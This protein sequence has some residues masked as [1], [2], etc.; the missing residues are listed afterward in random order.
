M[1]SF[2][3]TDIFVIGGGPAG[4]TIANR[5]AGMG[6][7]VLLAEAT[8]FPRHRVDASLP[9]IIWPLL[10]AIGVTE[11]IA[12]A[13]FIP[14]RAPIVVWPH[15]RASTLS[16]ERE[17][18]G[19]YVERARFDAILLEAAALAGV[20]TIEGARA[21]RPVRDE[22][23]GWR[24]PIKF[25]ANQQTVVSSHIIV[26]ASGGRL[27]PGAPSR[28]GPTTLAVFARWDNLS[29]EPQRAILEA[30]ENE[31]LWCAPVGPRELIAIAFIEPK[32]LS[33][34]DRSAI[35]S[36]YLEILGRS[37][38]IGSVLVDARLNEIRICDATCRAAE[39]H[40]ELGY[41][42]VGDASLK[43]DP[44]SSQGV[45]VAIASALQAAVIANTMLRKPQSSSMAINFYDDRQRERLGAHI[46]K[47]AS[48]YNKVAS[49]FSSQFWKE[50][51]ASHEPEPGE[52]LS[53]VAALRTD[54]IIEL[55]SSARFEEAAVIEGD[56]VVQRLGLRLPEWR[57]PIAYLGP[58]AI[59]P[60]LQSTTFSRSL[61]AIIIEWRQSFPEDICWSVA[62]WLWRKGVLE[63]RGKR[64]T[65]PV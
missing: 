26:D 22:N 58:V 12:G 52:H 20:H 1:T 2:L 7:S 13:Q 46:R 42:R 53:P 54:G 51:S 14:A 40:A 5:L 63:V 57:A 34:C 18:T 9:A 6:H 21:S 24:T 55:A 29:R 28:R 32:R 50:R 64:T 30:C 47:S 4:A 25:G 31:W 62:H 56:L 36:T 60:L 17:Q 59:A 35:H 65:P 61:A 49:H 44:L 3:Q 16:E 38:L 39:T 10:D 27:L 8:V 43:L 19:L 37:R 15:D 45:P 33:R 23:G 41:L 11:R 48:L